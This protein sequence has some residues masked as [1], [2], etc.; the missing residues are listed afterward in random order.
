MLLKYQ[1]YYITGFLAPP[2]SYDS[3]FGRVREAQRTS[4]GVLEFLKNLLII[5]L[6]TSMFY[7][8]FFKWRSI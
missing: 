5:L 3:L 8:F 6:G 1:I 2:P 7:L 4:K